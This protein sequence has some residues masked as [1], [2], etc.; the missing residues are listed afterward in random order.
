MENLLSSLSVTVF[1]GILALLAQWSR[2]SRRAEISLWVVVVFLSLLSLA[3]GA[4][5]GAVSFTGQVPAEVY[6]PGLLVVTAGAVVAAGLIGLALCVPTLRKIV[7]R[8]PNEGFWSDPPIFLALWLFVTV[9]LA[10]NLVGILGFEQLE[11]GGAFSLGTGGRVSPGVILASQLPFLVVA[12][13]GVG[14]GVR[15]SPRQT[16]ARL[17]YGPISPKQLGVVALFAVSAFALSLAADHLFSLL[18]PD[19][20]R[21]VGRVSRALFDPRGLS[22]VSAVLFALLIGLGAGLGEETLFRGAVQPALGILPTSLLF[23][24]MHV[25]YGPSLLLG[26]IFLLSIGLGL[27]RRYINTTASFVAHASYNVISI[28]A[29]YFFAP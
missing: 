12:V 21:D 1:V 20:Y 23:A 18:Q 5:L 4:L 9:L 14:A 25:Q 11:R 10:N 24:S 27:L 3:T 15:R 2:K 17:G 6:P 19:L 26:Y 13:L 29:A 28:L 16:L 22:P 7:G 8:G